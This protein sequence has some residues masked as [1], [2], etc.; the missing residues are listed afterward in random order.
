[1]AD[2]DPDNHE[3]DDTGVE[4]ADSSDSSSPE[5]SATPERPQRQNVNATGLV[6]TLPDGTHLPG[7]RA[8]FAALVLAIL[9]FSFMLVAPQVPVDD[10]GEPLPADFHGVYLE[11]RT[12]IEGDPV[13]ANDV[14]AAEAFGWAFMVVFLV[15]LAVTA[16]AWY[17]HRR[18]GLSRP[19]TFG[20]LAMA[21]AVLFTGGIG[22]YFLPALIALA[23]G[24]FQARKAEMPARLAERAARQTD[25]D[26]HADE[27]KADGEE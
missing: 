20:M 15:P 4:D 8:T 1:M 5:P 21:V 3:A 18:T 11:V 13:E 2:D 12:M 14:T 22:Q 9:A 6:A 26:Q 24:S 27:N 17:T 25:E 7:A 19:L 16:F 10:R 23:V